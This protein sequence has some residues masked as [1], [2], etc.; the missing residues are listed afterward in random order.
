MIIS[1]CIYFAANDI[2]SFFFMVLL[3]HCIHIF[4]IHSSAD[5]HLGCFH[6]LAIVNSDVVNIRMHVSFG[7]MVFSRYA[8]EWNC[9]IIW[10]SIFSFLRN[11]HTV[12]RNGCT[13][14]HSQR[15]CRS[16]LQSRMPVALTKLKPVLLCT[17][18]LCI[19][20]CR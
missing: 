6:V 5:G 3:F 9:W 10:G 17:C 2:T 14:L 4:F 8:Q 18:G 15:Q 11:L 19:K 12:F 16:I 13:N 20:Q 7:I 1:E